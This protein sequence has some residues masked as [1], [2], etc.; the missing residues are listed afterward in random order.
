MKFSRGYIENTKSF[1]TRFRYILKNDN[2]EPV[3]TSKL[4]R[5]ANELMEAVKI[6]ERGYGT[7]K[8]LKSL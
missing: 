8:L 3:R 5:D 1:P 6:W 7:A 4:F 2:G